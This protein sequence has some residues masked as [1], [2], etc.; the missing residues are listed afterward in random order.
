[1][2]RGVGE[3]VQRGKRSTVGKPRG[4]FDDTRLPVGAAV[5]DRQYA[6]RFSAELTCDGVEI[7]ALNHRAAAGAED[8]VAERA[9]PEPGCYVVC[10]RSCAT[11]TCT[12]GHRTTVSAQTSPAA[13][14][15]R[16]RPAA[17]A[18]DR[19]CRRA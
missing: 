14:R 18:P 19:G 8:R 6:A 16:P 2:Q 17:A 5:G 15:V 3:V 10:R 7:G 9:L 1:G 4:G 13:P 11:A 12:T